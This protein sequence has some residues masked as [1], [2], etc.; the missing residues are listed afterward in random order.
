MK[1]GAHSPRVRRE[2]KGLYP[3]RTGAVRTSLGEVE[4]GEGLGDPYRGSFAKRF[5]TRQKGVS[6]EGR[7]GGRSRSHLFMPS[8]RREGESEDN[9]RPK[10]NGLSIKLYSRERL[11]GE[12]E[13]CPRHERTLFSTH[14][15]MTKTEGF[16]AVNLLSLESKSSR[17]WESGEHERKAGS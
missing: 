2:C 3:N 5:G 1:G 4:T 13:R 6:G 7:W 9:R 11:F 14:I 12:R 16:G 10:G 8:V 15:A 17:I